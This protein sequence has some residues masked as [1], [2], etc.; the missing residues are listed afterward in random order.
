V[1]KLIVLAA[2]LARIGLSPIAWLARP[3]RRQRDR[4]LLG[5]YGRLV[6]ALPGM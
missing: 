3:S 4:E 2:S 5:R 1:Y 6:R